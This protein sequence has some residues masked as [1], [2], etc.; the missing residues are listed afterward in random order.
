MVVEVPGEPGACGL[1]A[2]E[3]GMCRTGKMAAESTPTPREDSGH[4]WFLLAVVPVAVRQCVPVALEQGLPPVPPSPRSPL[5][6]PV[7]MTFDPRRVRGLCFSVTW[8][9]PPRLTLS[10]ALF[11]ADE[12]L[13][14]DRFALENIYS[15][16]QPSLEN[17][18]PTT[19]VT[20]GSVPS[21]AIHHPGL[22]GGWWAPLV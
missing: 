2:E 18:D 13:K 7:A 14:E 20:Q 16:F 11:S 5:S 8:G 4:C 17:V 12:N 19:E 21:P 3:W 6:L 22:P 9:Q 10:P 15:H 1:E